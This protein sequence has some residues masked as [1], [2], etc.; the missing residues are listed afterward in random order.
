[1]TELSEVLTAFGIASDSIV[2]KLSGGKINSTWLVDGHDRRYILQRVNPVFRPGMIDDCAA[3]LDELRK[4]DWD[5]PEVLRTQSGQFY[6]SD[7]GIWRLSTFIESDEQLPALSSNLLYECGKLLARLH[8]SLSKI[9]RTI[10][11]PLPHYRDTAFHIA[12]LKTIL[13]SLTGDAHDLAVRTISTYDD[14]SLQDQPVAPQ[15][16]H[17]D[18][19][20][21]N[22]LFRDQHPYTYIDW[23]A[24]MTASPLIDLGDFV[25]SLTKEHS[26]EDIDAL[27][28]SFGQGYYDSNNLNFSDFDEFSTATLSAAK[29][30]ALENVA[31]YLYDIV[32]KSFWEWDASKYPTQEQAMLDQAFKTWR[33]FETLDNK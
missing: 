26:E 11:V 24:L 7:D 14:Q 21:N 29:V 22:I 6:Y 15:L 33:I 8:A 3:V 17:G 10:P 20:M 27:I 1:M 30:I 13:P 32:D 2:K 4:D 19:K 5:V 12:Y 16:I 23:D 25:R 9:Q 18:P 28:A 31:R